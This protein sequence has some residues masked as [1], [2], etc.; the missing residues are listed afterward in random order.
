M[1][2][3]VPNGV[4]II[5]A[6]SDPVYPLR[7]VLARRNPGL[8]VRDLA[9]ATTDLDQLVSALGDPRT[10]LS[11]S[12]TD[13]ARDQAKIVAR[14]LRRISRRLYVGPCGRV[15]GHSR[16]GRFVSVHDRDALDDGGLGALARE[17][18]Y[19]SRALRKAG[20]WSGASMSVRDSSG[21]NTATHMGEIG[22]SLQAVLRA[23]V[24]DLTA[25][26][27]TGIEPGEVYGISAIWASGT[28]WPSG[29][30]QRVR[31]LS[32]EVGPGVFRI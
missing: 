20:P 31:A 3:P 25:A 10:Y 8:L 2:G 6:M 21:Q 11:G 19:I 14:Q 24:L 22:Q 7:C 5:S 4:N 1:P 28:V 27:L 23:T 17:V 13:A 16:L 32:R 18:A 26:D 15:R 29:M 12:R 30:A 9:A